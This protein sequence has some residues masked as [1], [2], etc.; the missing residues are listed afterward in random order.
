MPDENADAAAN[1]GPH[2]AAEAVTPAAESETQMAN[3]QS[4][5][6]PLLPVLIR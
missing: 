4:E 5:D 6:G 1:A 3:E 2:V